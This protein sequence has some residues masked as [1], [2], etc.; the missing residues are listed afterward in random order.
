[1]SSKT[2]AVV[3]L[4]IVFFISLLSFSVGTF[5]G[6]KYSDNQHQLAAL[7]PQKGGGHGSP[8]REVASTHDTT[9]TTESKPG[10][11]TDEEIAKLAEEFVADETTAPV[12]ATGHDT[13]GAPTGHHEEAT[14]PAPTTTKAS[15]HKPAE[16]KASEAKAEDKKAPVTQHQEPLS[17]AKNIAAGKEPTSAH[18]TTAK[19][20]APKEER[21]PSSI[22]KDVAQYSVGKFTVQVASYASESEAQKMASELK[23]RGY[24]AFYIPAN[25][26]GKTWYRVSVGQFAT[27]KEA[28]SYRVEFLN[29][30]KMESAIVQKIVE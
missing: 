5:V 23:N 11:M 30:A 28:Q 21:L 1:M 15:E 29:K 6:K 2:D 12:T 8:E 26:Q 19:K 20:T 13:H 24:S 18:E 27:Q 22:P 3:K 7:E 9:S 10:A 4:A 14:A 25:I 17:A 16:H